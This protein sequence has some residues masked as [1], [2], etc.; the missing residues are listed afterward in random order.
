[1]SNG[2]VFMSDLHVPHL[3]AHAFATTLSL[4]GLARPSVVIIGGDGLDLPQLGRFV[5]RPGRDVEL[6]RDL[7]LLHKELSR[8]RRAAP[9]ADMWYFQGN[10][11]YRATTYKWTNPA[12]SSLECLTI[13]ALL[14]LGDLNIKYVESGERKFGRTLFRHGTVVRSGSGASARGELEQHGVSGVSGHTHKAEQVSLT[15]A[16][17]TYE[18][19]GAGCLCDLS[20]DYLDIKVP[21]WQHGIT[22]TDLKAGRTQLL[23]IVRGVLHFG[24]HVING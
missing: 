3:N 5:K 12:I 9:D 23:K 17:G 7:K 10:H 22:Y 21:S 1:M 8:V 19:T 24:E 16:S 6:Q 18:W 4:I 13:P 20:A 11:E 15:N 14:K 2:L